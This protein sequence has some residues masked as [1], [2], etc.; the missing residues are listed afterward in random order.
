MEPADRRA[1]PLRILAL[2]HNDGTEVCTF[3][4]LVTPLEALRAAG[5]VDYK[6][7]TVFLSHIPRLQALLRDLPNWDLIWV[8]RPHH[9]SLLPFIREARRLGKPV[10]IDIDDWL[11]HVPEDHSDRAYFMNRPTQETIRLALQ[12]ATAVTTSTEVIARYCAALGLQAHVVPNTVDCAR[13]ARLP[14][15]NSVTTIGFC[16][17]MTHRPDMSLVSSGLRDLLQRY[18]ARVRVVSMGCPLPEL[19]DLPGYTY[20]EPV[21][22]TAY[23]EAMSNLRLD[24]GLAPLHDTSFNRAKSDIKYLEYA[25]TGAATIASPAEPYMA[26]VREDRGMLVA[27]NTPEVWSDAMERLVA[28]APLRHRLA[29]EAYAWVCRERS[30]TAAVEHYYSLFLHYIQGEAAV[31]AHMYRSAD[32]ERFDHTMTD[33]VM[34]QL[35]TDAMRVFAGLTQQALARVVGQT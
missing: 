34:R 6:L 16:G 15:A 27:T 33:I 26:S 21:A 10:L 5:L 30:T 28:D 12:T 3:A 7:Q 4:R 11:L 32:A 22:A 9:Y 25:A 24:I 35:P 8:L 18:P 20:H 29:E 31:H 13:Y 17:S 14:R 1:T 23:A 2:S 19:E